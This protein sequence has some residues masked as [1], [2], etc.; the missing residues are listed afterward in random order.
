MFPIALDVTKIRIALVGSGEAFTRRLNQLQDMQAAHLLIYENTLP[1]AHE[2]KQ[3]AILMVVGLDNDTS[4][5][6]ASIARLQGVLVNVEDKPELCDFY[7]TSFLQ[8][9]DLTLAIS[10]NGKSPTVAQEIKAYLHRLFG[11]EWNDIIN[12]IGTARLDWREQGLANHE[13][14][15]RTRTILQEKNLLT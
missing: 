1:E 13:I 11:E 2:I 9:G 10:T 12:D 6:L 15:A 3:V 8:R 5:V 4:A 7:F 14:A